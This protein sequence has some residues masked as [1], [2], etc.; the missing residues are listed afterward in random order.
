MKKVVVRDLIKSDE[1]TFEANLSHFMQELPGPLL[2]L[3]FVASDSP[4]HIRVVAI[5]EN[6]TCTS[7]LTEDL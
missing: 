4:W 2:S 5:C 1:E 7:L 3:N 6:V